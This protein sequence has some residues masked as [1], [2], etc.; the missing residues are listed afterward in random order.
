LL[1]IIDNRYRI[2][3][4]KTPMQIMPEKSGARPVTESEIPVTKMGGN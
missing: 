1:S 3:K 4:T 2:K